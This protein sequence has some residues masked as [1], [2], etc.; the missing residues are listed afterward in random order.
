MLSIASTF[1]PLFL[2]EKIISKKWQNI[3]LSAEYD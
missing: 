1:N 2:P 3:V